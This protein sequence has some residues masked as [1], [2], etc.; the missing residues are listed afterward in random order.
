VVAVPLVRTLAV[1]GLLRSLASP[2]G[3]VIKA[4]G[5]PGLLALLGAIRAAV[6]VPALVIAGRTASPLAIAITLTAVMAA[7]TLLNQAVASRVAHIPLRH[8][9]AQLVPGMLGAGVFAL[10]AVGGAALV[11]HLNLPRVALLALVGTAFGA[12][13]VRLH[14]PCLLSD[15]LSMLRAGAAGGPLAIEPGSW[16]PSDTTRAKAA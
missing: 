16:T 9:A 15:A 5:R 13:A 11:G 2:A 3:D 14:S 4:V 6:L 1:Y 8:V 7:A 10:I 12:I